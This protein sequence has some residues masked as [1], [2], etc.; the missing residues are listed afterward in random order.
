MPYLDALQHNNCWI[1]AVARLFLS[2]YGMPETTAAQA[3]G[4]LAAFG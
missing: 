3:H 4:A 1:M 2:L